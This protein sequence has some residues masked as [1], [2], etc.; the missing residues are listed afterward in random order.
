[1]IKINLLD[2]ENKKSSRKEKYEDARDI[3]ICLISFAVL[4]Y[5]LSRG[6]LG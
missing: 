1:M 3:I 2:P 5:L 6:N 4:V